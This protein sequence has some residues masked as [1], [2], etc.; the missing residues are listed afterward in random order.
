MKAKKIFCLAF[1][2]LGMLPISAQEKMHLI[3]L[4]NGTALHADFYFNEVQDSRQIQENI[5]VAQKGMMNKQV[6]ANFTENFSLHLQSYF[7]SILASAPEKQALTVKFHKLYISERTSATSELGI[8]E[9]KL[10]FLRNENDNL[11]SLGTFQSSVEGKGMDVT[12]KHGERIKEAIEIC[13]AKFSATNWKNATIVEINEAPAIKHQFNS[14]LVLNKG[15]YFDFED[16]VNNAPKQDLKYRIKTLGENK[17]SAHYQVLQQ[18]KNKRIKNL[19]GYSDGQHIYLNSSRYTQSDYFIKS[20][21]I[22]RYIYFEDQ[23]SSPQAAAAFGLIGAAA[24][25]KH[26]GIVLDTETGIVRVL[27]NK[28]MEDILKEYPELLNEYRQGKKKIEDDRNMIAK[29]NKLK[30]II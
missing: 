2:V 27:N 4:E 25:T 15:L 29:I 3:K 19:F 11:I 7:N 14:K 18:E 12:P 16:I 10:E 28:N 30:E 26:T 9:V 17:K 13:I 8:C 22:G 5:G 6:P 24:S 1:V 23:Y 21:M 20:Q